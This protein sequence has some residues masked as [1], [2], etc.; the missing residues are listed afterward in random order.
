M[1]W[2]HSI[3]SCLE[4]IGSGAMALYHCLEL[5]GSVEH[6]TGALPGGLALGSSLELIGSATWHW[7]IAGSSVA[8]WSTALDHCQTT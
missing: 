4:L 3:G 1:T 6:G 5:S 8:A 2:R 7:I